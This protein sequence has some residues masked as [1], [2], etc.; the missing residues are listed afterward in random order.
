M[1]SRFTSAFSTLGIALGLTAFLAGLDRLFNLLTQLPPNT[2]PD[3]IL[4]PH[5]IREFD[6]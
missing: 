1:N 4:Q 2:L 5:R 3:N 6:R